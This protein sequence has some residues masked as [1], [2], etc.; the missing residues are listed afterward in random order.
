[1]FMISILGMIGYASIDAFVFSEIQPLIDKSLST[2]DHH[3]LRL[4][5]YF[6]VP[7]ILMRGVFNFI[8]TY[9]LSWIGSRVVMAMRQQLFDRFMRLPV[10]YHH[11]LLQFA[12]ENHHQLLRWPRLMSAIFFLL[13]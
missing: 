12:A 3:Y 5:A 8:G 13:I 1:M 2:G 10:E 4:V 6:F 11:Q 7:V 9:S